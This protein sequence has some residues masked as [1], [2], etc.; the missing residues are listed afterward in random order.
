MT[1]WVTHGHTV[2]DERTI[3]VCGSWSFQRLAAVLDWAR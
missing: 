3:F 1:D 2:D